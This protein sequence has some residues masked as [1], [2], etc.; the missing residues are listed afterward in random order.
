M[1]DAFDTAPSRIEPI[2]RTAAK[3]KLHEVLATLEGSPCV[4]E[5]L[6]P[7][8]EAVAALDAAHAAVVEEALDNAAI[9]DALIR[10][11]TSGQLRSVGQRQLIEAITGHEGLRVSAEEF[12]LR[13]RSGGPVKAPD[14]PTTAADAVEPAPPVCT[15]RERAEAPA[16]SGTRAASRSWRRG[17]SAAS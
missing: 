15:S 1:R 9:F 11:R 8:R 16:P 3:D 10:A 4:D 7:L 13:A 14:A 12:V 6:G 2:S 5:E 17:P